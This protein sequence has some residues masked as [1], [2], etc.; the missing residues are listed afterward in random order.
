M[1]RETTMTV[2]D[3][4]QASELFSAYW[5]RDLGPA[6]PEAS[7]PFDGEPRDGVPPDEDDAGDERPPA[8]AGGPT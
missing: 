6:E 1:G 2:V 3:H 5:E 7:D 4:V 8:A